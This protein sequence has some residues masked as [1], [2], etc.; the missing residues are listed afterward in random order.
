MKKGISGHT[1]VIVITLIVGMIGLVIFWLFLQG[2]MGS[3]KDFIE[4]VSNQMKE[5]FCSMFRLG[6]LFCK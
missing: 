6:F 4:K 2:T 5:A 1:L 3:A